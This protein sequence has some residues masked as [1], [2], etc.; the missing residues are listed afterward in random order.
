MSELRSLIDELRTVDHRSSSA[1]ELNADRVELS[2][3]IDQMKV[4]L[5]EKMAILDETAV[6]TELGYPSIIRDV[7]YLRRGTTG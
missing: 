1:D 5:A 6:L 3:G 4:L 2:R 7:V